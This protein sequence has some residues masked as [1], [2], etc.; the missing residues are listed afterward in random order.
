[1]IY[2]STL[3]GLTPSD[4]STVHIYIQTIHK[5]TQIATEQRHEDTILVQLNGDWKE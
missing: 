2:L 1:M 5:T 4:S 3:I